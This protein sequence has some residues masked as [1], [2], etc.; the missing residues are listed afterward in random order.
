MPTQKEG[1]ASGVV[2]WIHQSDWDEMLGVTVAICEQLE[3]SKVEVIQHIDD[4][5]TAYNDLDNSLNHLCEATC[6]ACEDVCCIKATV[7]Y[8]RRDIIVYHLVT[9]SFPEKQVSRSAAGIC[10]HLGENGCRLPRIERPFICTWYICAAQLAI[11][12]NKLAAPYTKI[13][14][15]IHWIKETRKIIEALCLQR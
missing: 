10:C 7:W 1:K 8:D 14:G 15:Q 12:R 5:I 6:P 2:P 11:L 4:I 9:G 3:D 13:Q